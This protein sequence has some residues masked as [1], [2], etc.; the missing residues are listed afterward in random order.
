[1]Q[2]NIS[3]YVYPATGSATINDNAFDFFQKNGFVVL[4][5]FISTNIVKKVKKSL[6]QLSKKELDDKSGVFYGGNYDSTK[7]YTLQRI[8]NLLNKGK[9][10]QDLIINE[11]LLH[12]MNKIFDRDTPH[13]KFYLSSFQANILK[14]GAPSQHLHIDTPV[15]E[16]LPKWPIKANSIFLINDFNKNNGATEV[17]PKSHLRSK[18]PKR[19]L[20]SDKKGIIK[21][22][23]PAGS[24]IITHGA[25]WHNSSENNSNTIRYALLGS[26]AASYA[27]EISTEEDILRSMNNLDLENM[28]DELYRL[29][30]GKHGIKDK[31]WAKK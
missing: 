22:I 20:E 26:F 21:V 30:G 18:K 24:V 10:F 16:P 23:A 3:E 4:S 31:K 25:L 12:W 19:D 13:D 28:N 17:V 7:H 27:R 6:E 15:P 29:I 8:W 1:M 5:D 14:P 9:I 2:N 11:E